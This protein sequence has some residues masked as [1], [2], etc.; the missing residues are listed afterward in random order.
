MLLPELG[1]RVRLTLYTDQATWDPS[2]ER[3]AQVQRYELDRTLWSA[4]NRGDATIFQVGNSSEAHRAIWLAS[5]QH[6]GVV[7]L[8]DHR[9]HHLFAELLASD[10]GDHDAYRAAMET[11]YG[12]EGLEAAGEYLA[13]RVTTEK[14]ALRYPLTPLTLR[15]CL[16]VIVHSKVAEREVGAL[17]RRPLARAALPF[18]VSPESSQDDPCDPADSEQPG[19]YSVIVFANGENRR[20]DPFLR[21]LAGLPERDAFRV[22]VVGRVERSE[23]LADEIRRLGLGS[24]VR[25]RGFVTIAEL[26]RL[27]RQADLAVN[28]RY[29]TM[30]EASLSQL[31]IFEWGVP[32]LVTRADW[33]ADLPSEAVLFVRPENE[34]D[35]LRRH[36]GSFAAAPGEYRRRGRAGRQYLE[37]SHSVRAYC[38]LLLEFVERCIRARAAAPILGLA[39]RAGGAL[40]DLLGQAHPSPIDRVTEVIQSLFGS[41]RQE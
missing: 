29:P 27:L 14:M 39:E 18:S 1:R 37:G 35:D 20:L 13:G 26:Q 4:L 38:D 22:E 28:L 34:I 5:Q 19:R 17:A 12:A 31:R 36:L 15:N 32:S 16:G 8:H 10:S 3:H 33:Y 2:L 9:L 23:R 30:G 6:P 21:A 24:Q 7:V 40:G 25:L 11:H 41:G